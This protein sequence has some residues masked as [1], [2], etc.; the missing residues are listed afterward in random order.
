MVRIRSSRLPSSSAFYSFNILL[1]GLRKRF[2]LARLALKYLK[3]D[4][5]PWFY[6]SILP[7]LTSGHFPRSPEWVSPGQRSPPQCCRISPLRTLTRAAAECK[8][9]GELTS[10]TTLLLVAS[11]RLPIALAWAIMIML[12]VALVA[13]VARATPTLLS[14]TV[15][16][17]LILKNISKNDLRRS[18]ALHNAVG[19]QF[20]GH[21]STIGFANAVT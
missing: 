19:M 8:E 4:S 14:V 3:V 7:P 11:C 6:S 15:T 21:L 1:L 9:V 10:A 5:G 18:I 20:C 17:P 13:T 12:A 2:W 16:I